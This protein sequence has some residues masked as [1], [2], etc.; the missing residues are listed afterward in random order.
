MYFVES[1]ISLMSLFINLISLLVKERPAGGLHV[2][3]CFLLCG[4]L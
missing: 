4:L 1:S 2:S 3:V